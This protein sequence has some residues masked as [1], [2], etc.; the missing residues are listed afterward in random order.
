MV[1]ACFEY[2]L[3]YLI[4]ACLKLKYCQLNIQ[5]LKIKLICLSYMYENHDHT[6]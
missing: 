2:L 1:G 3:S 6:K 4:D 5:I